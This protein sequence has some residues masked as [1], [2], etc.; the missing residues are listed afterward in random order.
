VVSF[1]FKKVSHIW[2]VGAPDALEED[3]GAEDEDAC[4]AEDVPRLP[5]AEPAAQEEVVLKSM[6]IFVSKSI[7]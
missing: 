3:E 7:M 5:A 4:R 1:N 6:Y 2:W